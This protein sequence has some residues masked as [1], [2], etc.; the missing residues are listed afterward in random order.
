MAR[1]QTVPAR[2]RFRAWVVGIGGAV[3]AADK[4]GISRARV[5]QIIKS[6][7]PGIRAAIAIQ[8]QAGIAV[9]EW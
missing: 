5:Y 7:D 4:L 9:T 2:D 6:D 8:R 3:E 1:K